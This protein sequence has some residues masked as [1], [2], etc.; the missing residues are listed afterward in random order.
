MNTT[1]PSFVFNFEK[2]LSGSYYTIKEQALLRVH[3]S[4][5][6]NVNKFPMV[7]NQEIV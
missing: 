6:G 1:V 3:N 2:I 4:P 5:P 7:A